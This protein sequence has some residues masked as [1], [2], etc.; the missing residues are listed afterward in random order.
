MLRK[1]SFL[2]VIIFVFSMKPTLCQESAPPRNVISKTVIGDCDVYVLQDSTGE[3]D[4]KVFANAA[5]EVL[6]EIAPTGKTPNAC[7]VFLVKYDGKNVLIDTAFGKNLLTNLNALSVEP[8]D[9]SAVLITHSHGDHV[10]GLLKDGNRFFPNAEIY[11]SETEVAFWKESNARQFEQVQK[12]YGEVKKFT[13]DE[14]TSVVLPVIHPLAMPGH[15]PGHTGFLI[16]TGKERLFVAGD[17]LHSGAIQFSHPEICASF[18]KDISQAV[19]TRRAML[20]RTVEEGWFFTAVH[21]RIPAVGTVKKA[22]DGFWF[23]PQEKDNTIV[24]GESENK[25]IEI[26]APPN[27]PAL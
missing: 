3:F 16:G 13:T 19:E 21:L 9:I 24:F 17:L 14:K 26:L 22:G 2:F 1:I 20:N 10:G 15:T 23:V 18:D 25:G 11:A 5:T 12:A 6:K 7:N 8:K 4:N 27:I